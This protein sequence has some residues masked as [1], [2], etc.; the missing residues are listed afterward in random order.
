MRQRWFGHVNLTGAGRGWACVSITLIVYGLIVDSWSCSI[1]N[2]LAPRSPFVMIPSAVTRRR[3]RYDSRGSRI[4]DGQRIMTR[5]GVGG[6]RSIIITVGDRNHKFFPGGGRG[7]LGRRNDGGL[8]E[9][10]GLS[11][12][13]PSAYTI[14]RPHNNSNTSG[15]DNNNLI[16]CNDSNN[17]NTTVADND[18]SA[19]PYHT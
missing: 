2:C 10:R 6:I 18:V 3:S 13:K 11:R 7:T 17:N 4:G 8:A 12:H 14:T 5:R 19:I 9:Q 1:Y 16:V 15:G